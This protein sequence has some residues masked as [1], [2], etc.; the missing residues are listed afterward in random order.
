MKNKREKLEVPLESAMNCKV[1]DKHGEIQCTQNNSRKTRYECITEA[2]ESTRSRIG[3]TQPRGHEDVV[4]KKGFNSMSHY[5]LVHNRYPYVKQLREENFVL[6]TRGFVLPS[7]AGPQRRLWPGLRARSGFLH[8]GVCV[9]ASCISS[10]PCP[11]LRHCAL[12]SQAL[13]I[14]LQFGVWLFVAHVASYLHAD[15]MPR[16]GDDKSPKT[17]SGG[18]G[19]PPG[20]AMAGATLLVHEDCCFFQQLP[21][22]GGTRQHKPM[23]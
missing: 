8:F 7:L 11:S 13:L 17:F 1:V 15:L 14:A 4:A 3:P 19:L 20:A 9:R 2:H 22:T 21:A 6:S 5:K 18:S 23:P 10:A 16:E 12:D